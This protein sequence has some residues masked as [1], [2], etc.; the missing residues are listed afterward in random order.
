MILE[1]SIILD[2]EDSYSGLMDLLERSWQGPI[3][4]RAPFLPPEI[5][6]E[7]KDQTYW[8]YNLAVMFLAVNIFGLVIIVL[9]LSD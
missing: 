7:K 8:W 4:E 1:D 9:I 6:H 2:I 3:I 5:I